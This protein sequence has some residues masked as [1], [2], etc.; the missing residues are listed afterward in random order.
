MSLE[1]RRHLG[2]DLGMGKIRSVEGSNL[3]ILFTRDQ[4][5]GPSFRSSVQRIGYQGLRRFRLVT[6][7]DS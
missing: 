1:S 6:S 4:E 2:R 3:S 7:P 5:W